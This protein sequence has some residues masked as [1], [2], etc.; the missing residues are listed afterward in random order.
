MEKKRT[1]VRFLA[2]CLILTVL[3]GC[4]GPSDGWLD[5]DGSRYYYA[6]GR[7]LTGWQ[8]I[9]ES[10]Y[11]FSESGVMTTGH[12]QLDGQDYY[13]D[14]SGVMATGWQLLDGNYYYFRD[15]GSRVNGWLSLDGVH[16]YLTSDGTAAAGPT[17]VDGACYL[18]D[19]KGTLTS[20]WLVLDGNRY[21]G[22]EHGRPLTGWQELDGIRYCFGEDFSQ[23]TGWLE[24]NGIQYYFYDG[25]VP[26][27]GRITLGGKEFTFGFNGQVVT[28][29]N[30]W[31]HVSADYTVELQSIGNGHLVAAYAASDYQQM[32]D[33]CRAAGL[34]PVVCSSYRTQE[35]QQGL[36]ERRIQR[37]MDD[38]Y[39]REEA[40]EKAGKS[41]A[42]PGTSEH[43]LG[44]ALDIIDSSNWNLDESQA[45]MPTQQW[46]MEHSWEYGWILRYPDEKS[47]ITGIIYEPWH[48]RYVGRALAADI[49]E[50]G[51]CLEEYLESLSDCVS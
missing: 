29:V 36:Y 25:G 30:P 17:E 50:T 27:Q 23:Q 8:K 42:I 43:Q 15:S 6:G 19:E 4:A 32:M 49:H 45:D 34:S 28:L 38:G 14:A 16:H 41:V 48:Y 11:Y 51:L 22:D 31:N 44:L 46:L 37:Y 3:T 35:Y 7:A 33:D 10:T 18:F 21:Y 47:E 2:L 1:A 26:A 9:D 39:T 5:R 20:G 40:T 24:E 13:F 12:F